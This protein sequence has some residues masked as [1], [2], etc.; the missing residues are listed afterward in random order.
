[1]IARI[2]LSAIFIFSFWTNGNTQPNAIVKNWSTKYS[3]H[4]GSSLEI[5]ED[6]TIEVLN[7][8]G[9][10]YGRFIDYHDKFKK[11]RKLNIEVVDQYGK[12]VKKLKR[13]DALD[14]N[15][16][17]SY[18]ID[19]SRLLVLDTDFKQYPFTI[20]VS[21]VSEINGFISL[22]TWSPMKGYNLE[23]NN[24]SLEIAYPQ[25][26]ELKI[27]EEN[28]ESFSETKAEGIITKK[29]DIAK[30]EYVPQSV[31][32][33][34]FNKTQPHILLSPREFELD[35]VSGNF[36]NWASFGD[37]FLKLNNDRDE[38]TQETKDFLDG[39]KEEERE[40]VIQKIYYYM[41]DKTRYVSIQLGIGGFQT[42]PSDVVE[43]TGYG[44]CKALTN[45]M[46]AML[47][48]AKIS[49][50]YIL[51]N[52]GSNAIDVKKNFPSNQFNHVF[53]G[54][55]NNEDTVYLECTSQIIP[56]N[57][58]G[59][60]TDDRN[61][62]WIENNKS[63]IIRSKKYSE[64]Q[65]KKVTKGTLLL[66]NEGNAVIQAETTSEGIYFDELMYYKHATKEAAK[67]KNYS[68]FKFKN[69][70][71]KNFE[72]VEHERND[73]TFTID[74]EISVKGLGKNSSGKLLIPYNVWLPI[75]NYLDLD[76]ITSSVEINRGF[77]IEDEFEMT[78]SENFWI[79]ELPKNKTVESPY[80]KYEV[81]IERKDSTYL[82]KRKVLIK[83]GFYENESFDQF[84]KMI[85]QIKKID[86]SKLV[87]DSKT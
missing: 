33:I 55:P 16:N 78:V 72:F 52:A 40:Q 58:Q 54:V 2:L 12:R 9:L 1:M 31:S 45:Y 38:L 59:K 56:A 69:F 60:F 28:I 80:G 24:V 67:Q 87:F 30:L 19:D 65:N 29:W 13:G 51:V 25:D 85:K 76:N 39:I 83:K 8:D 20:T 32:K 64:D 22:P 68:K 86:N 62:L 10:N 27:L 66:S 61:I 17:N 14:V 3:V 43:E 79:M 49:S 73:Q 36:E 44:D 48:Y 53:L 34:S 23:L 46:K 74:Y 77:T 6:Y 75:D 11:I 42:I 21:T 63:K 5:A 35:G 71:I 70:E 37:W 84:K 81:N 57:Y 4:N 26:F 15:F 50:N 47:G 41:Q 18:Q 7:K 82:L